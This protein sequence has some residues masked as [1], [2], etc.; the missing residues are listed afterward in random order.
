MIHQFDSDLL[1]LYHQCL[2]L[3]WIG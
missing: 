2:N 3:W 1:T